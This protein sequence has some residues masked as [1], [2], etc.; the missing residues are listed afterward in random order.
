MPY[1]PRKQRGFLVFLC[2][3][4]IYP[5]IAQIQLTLQTSWFPSLP[6]GAAFTGEKPTGWMSLVCLGGN[7]W[8]FR[9]LKVVERSCQSSTVDWDVLG[10]C[11]C[12]VKCCCWSWVV[13]YPGIKYTCHIYLFY[14][15]E[16]L[17]R[18]NNTSQVNLPSPKAQWTLCYVVL[19]LHGGGDVS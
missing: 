14:F 18:L 16:V 11:L 7:G 3:M 5:V 10:H 6:Q 2:E 4:N 9:Q 1:R 15:W 19:N 17:R 8:S 13:F 12:W